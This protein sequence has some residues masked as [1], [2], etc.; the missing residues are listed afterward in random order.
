MLYWKK[1]PYSKKLLHCW[2]KPPYWKKLLHCSPSPGA[3]TPEL[4]VLVLQLLLDEPVAL[5]LVVLAIEL[6]ALELVVQVLELSE[7][8]LGRS[9][10]VSRGRPCTGDIDLSFG[11]DL[12]GVFR[13]S[14]FVTAG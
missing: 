11:G 9:S 12:D 13:R 10:S 8:E 4:D 5:E 2:R 7:L 14:S 1:P 6:F 3:S